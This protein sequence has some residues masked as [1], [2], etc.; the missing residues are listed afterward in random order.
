MNL[1]SLFTG[2][3]ALFLIVSCSSQRRVVTTKEEQRKYPKREVNYSVK[4][5]IPPPASKPK[6]SAPATA[7]TSYGNVVE[8][9]IGRYKAIAKEEMSVYGVPASVTLAQG[10]LESGAGKSKLAVEANNHFGIKCGNAWEG[11]KAYHKGACFRRYENA[12]SSFRDHSLFLRDRSH[13]Q[14][15]F[16]LP[17]DDYVGWAKGLRKAGYAVDRKYPE[18]LITIIE[19][20]QLYNYDAEVLSVVTQEPV[21]VVSPSGIPEDAF[22]IVKEGDTLYSI[23]RRYG[24]TV[25]ALMQMNNLSTTA[26]SIGQSLKIRS[27]RK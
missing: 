21:K 5:N 22:Y 18:K 1:N 23:S 27:Q 10:I 9:Y 15:L 20:Y 16:S 2:F 26:I 12:S 24:L 8:Q 19:K 3:I 17:Q 14:F 13:Y 4:E 25:E 6:V 11:A 7:G